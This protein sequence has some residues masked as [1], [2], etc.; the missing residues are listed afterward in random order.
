[1]EISDKLIFS[2]KKTNSSFAYR[3]I[4]NQDTKYD[5]LVVLWFLKQGVAGVSLS[6]Y[7]E[8]FGIYV[9]SVP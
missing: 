9:G 8:F 2:F 3:N 7:L 5:C 6:S 4:T 1:M